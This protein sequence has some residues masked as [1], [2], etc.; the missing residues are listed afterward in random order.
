MGSPNRLPICRENHKEIP[1]R[2]LSLCGMLIHTIS[3]ENSFFDI[4][5]YL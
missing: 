5:L 1:H 4:S 2:T 3:V